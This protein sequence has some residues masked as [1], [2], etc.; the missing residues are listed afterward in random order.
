MK[1]NIF[2]ICDPEETYACSLMDYLTARSNIPFEIRAFTS[3]ETLLTYAGVHRIE[4]LL[5]SASMLT[6]E[7]RELDIGRIVLLSENSLPKDGEELDSVYKYQ[8]CAEVLRETMAAYSESRTRIA[9]VFPA[10]KKSTCIYGIYSPLNRCGKT[11]FALALGQELAR[12]KPTFY[13]SLEGCSGLEKLMGRSFT[14]NLSDLLYYARQKDSALIHRLNGMLQTIGHL[15]FVPPVRFAEDIR[16]SS[17][18]DLEFLLGELLARSA[19]EAVILDVGC[20]TS[21]LL[22]LLDLCTTIYMPVLTDPVSEAKLEQYEA[23]LRTMECGRILSKTRKL[24]LPAHTETVPQE[25]YVSQL[26]WNGYGQMARDILAGVS[27]RGQVP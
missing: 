16:Q 22:A 13:L 2:A 10:L 1:R 25:S 19:Y 3:A 24:M 11:S 4:L 20:E 23:M 9:D 8:S 14:H 7:I 21:E 27:Q 15:D 18:E 17:W 12:N 6:R 5:I 26:L